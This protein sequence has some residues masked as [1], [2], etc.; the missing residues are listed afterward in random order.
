MKTVSYRM[1]A[2]FITLV[3][4]CKD[5]R[6]A[7]NARGYELR[8]PYENE[9]VRIQ[10]GYNPANALMLDV[11]IGEKEDEI[12]TLTVQTRPEKDET[13]TGF[14]AISGK[15]LDHIPYEDIIRTYR[16][17]IKG[18][19]ADVAA[20]ITY[21]S[22]KEL[23]E[24]HIKLCKK[25]GFNP[26]RGNFTQ[27]PDNDIAGGNRNLKSPIKAASL[28]ASNGLTL[29]IGGKQS[30]FKGRVYDK[31]AEVLA[32]TGEVIEP[33]LR[34]ELEVKQEV[35]NAIVKEIAN[36]ADLGH[37]LAPTLWHTL[38]D[39]HIAFKKRVNT[40]TLAEVMEIDK[41]ETIKLD[42]SKVEGKKLEYEHWLQKQVIPKFETLYGHLDLEKKVRALSRIGFFS[43]EEMATILGA[44]MRENGE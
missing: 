26:K 38:A 32:K 7:F 36:S 43:Q 16:D 11:Q 22:Q 12:M 35:A 31:S 14:I 4:N 8:D 24:A 2:M 17:W 6:D 3:P 37:D 18:T 5:F 23:D 1:D 42:Y 33:T 39:D 15:Q 19:R 13:V 29:Y 21:P 30:K 10:R 40:E 27:D 9:P 20:D 28:I 44:L 34:V 41:A 25:V